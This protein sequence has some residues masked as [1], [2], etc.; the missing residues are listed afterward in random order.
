MT[1]L[2]CSNKSRFSRK[3][4]FILLA[5]GFFLLLLLL[6]PA[7]G[8][9]SSAE[10]LEQDG[11]EQLEQSIDELLSALDLEELQA[12]LDSLSQFKGVS[13][14]D[15]LAS[16][17]SGDFALDYTSLFQ[18][19]TSL[20]WE[21]GKM[22]LPAF[23][24]ILAVSLVCGIL[25]SA[26]SGF[27]QSSMSDI[28]HFVSYIS[29][30][31]V[32]LSCLIT[33]L[34]AGF[35]AMS[36][37]RTQMELVY[38]L[39]LTLMAGS[40]GVVSAAVYRPAVAFMSGAITELFATVVLPSAIVI[41]VLAF[42]GNLT[43]DVRTEKLGELFK[44]V[45][46]WLIGLSLGLFSLFL[47]VQGITSAQYDGVSL[48]AAKYAVSSSVPIVGGFLSGGLD[49]VLAGSALIKNALGSF[50]VFMLLTTL[51]RPLVLLIVFQLFLRLA[52]AATE[53]VGGKTSSFLAHLAG[54]MGYFIAGILSVAFL[55]FL[56]LLLLICSSGVIF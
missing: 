49:I 14:K 27:L 17:I 19:V 54:D 24:V 46:K 22:L 41:I 25:N 38:P 44:S 53:P 42:V 33:V 9:G 39:L 10:E 23:V 55:Y 20:I 36:Q 40:G 7:G 31:S 4:K 18:S 8:V 48:R 28:I 56:T 16:V 15:K 34:S 52:A 11:Q 12:Y 29:V 45:S 43:S 3:S 50:A 1:K 37:M 6:F 21:E 51:L 26:K 5:V 13:L 2:Y 47:T 35:S 30:G 32:V